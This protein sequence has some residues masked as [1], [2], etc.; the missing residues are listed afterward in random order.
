MYIYLFKN[1][2]I[3]PQINKRFFLLL[4]CFPIMKENVNSITIICCSLGFFV[5]YLK[6]EPPQKFHKSLLPYTIVFWMF[7]IHELLSTDYSVKRILL[8]LPFLIFPFLFY[9]RPSYIGVK[10]KHQAL[11]LFQASVLVASGYFSWIFLKANSIMSL[12]NIS[13]E[14]IPFF[15]DYVYRNAMLDIHPTY[16]SIFL[17]IS[18]TLSSYFVI[19]D[20]TKEK[21][22]TSFHLINMLFV[23]VMLFLFSS[24][25]VIAIYAVTLL[26]IIFFLTKKFKRRNKIIILLCLIGFGFVILFSFKD[27]LSNRFNEVFTEYNVLLKGKHHNSTNI[28]VAIYNCGKELFSQMPTFGYGNKLQSQLNSCYELKYDSNFSKIQTYNTHNYYLNI[29][30]YGGWLF[31]LLFLF[32]L[33]MLALKIRYSFIASIIFL[34][35]LLICITENF[36]SRHYG[37]VTFTYFIGMFS[38]IQEPSDIKT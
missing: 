21:K 2:E 32:Y 34:Q 19:H 31:L 20:K 30:L 10:E 11:K 4:A 33:M 26:I 35:L 25:M 5:Q 28:R 24:R 8:H 7:F 18:F 12:F 23:T 37:I 22:V 27:I 13:Q 38:F 6:T 1:K 16:F 3:L 9:F 14:N 15:R 17:L 36:L 29:L